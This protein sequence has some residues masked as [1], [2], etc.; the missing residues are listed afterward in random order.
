MNTM[1]EELIFM[2]EVIANALIVI[3]KN[4]GD[5]VTHSQILGYIEAMEKVA[6]ISRVDV[7]FIKDSQLQTGVELRLA[8][9]VRPY[10]EEFI[11]KSYYLC[12]RD[13]ASNLSRRYHESLTA[14]RKALYDSAAVISY[15]TTGNG[16]FRKSESA[17]KIM[18][19]KI[20]PS[21]K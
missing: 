5:H 2:D 6:K 18:V 3:S 12:D 1:Y 11:G 17:E 19:Y 20:D 8:P 13:A 14:K 10:N 16:E 4:G 21:W 15:L 7:K 9:D